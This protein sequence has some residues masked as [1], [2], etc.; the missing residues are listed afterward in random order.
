MLFYIYLV[1][2]TLFKADL[3][4]SVTCSTMPGS[5]LV[6]DDKE[7]PTLLAEARYTNQL[8]I[9]PLRTSRKLLTLT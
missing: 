5:E 2:V 9:L 3:A 1:P 7:A 4:A 6:P 8:L